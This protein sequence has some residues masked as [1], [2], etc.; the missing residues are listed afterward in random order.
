MKNS[1]N[2]FLIVSQKSLKCESPLSGALLYHV[3]KKFCFEIGP[4]PG[5]NVRCNY[6]K[7]CCET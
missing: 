3:S 7:H 1:L 5:T 4:A 2:N 6:I